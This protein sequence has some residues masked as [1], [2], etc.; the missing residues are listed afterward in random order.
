ML[1]EPFDTYIK[2]YLKNEMNQPILQL[3]ADKDAALKDSYEVNI[4]DKAKSFTTNPNS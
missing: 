3:C 2:K 1:N 4:L